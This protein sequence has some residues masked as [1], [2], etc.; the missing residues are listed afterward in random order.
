M[1]NFDKEFTSKQPTLTPTDHSV[2]KGINQQEFNGFSF[3]ND[4]YKRPSTAPPTPQPSSPVADGGLPA[5]AE[6]N[7]S[8]DIAMATAVAS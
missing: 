8:K 6:V 3:V 7:S 1:S 2:V 4:D 5:I